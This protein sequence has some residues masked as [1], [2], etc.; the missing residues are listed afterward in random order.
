MGADMDDAH[1]LCRLLMVADSAQYGFWQPIKGNNMGRK[2]QR[3]GADGEREL[4][5]ILQEHGFDC[6]RGGSLSFGEVPDLS[7]LPGIHIEVK[8]VEKQN[9]YEWMA[10][11]HRDADKFRDGLPAVFWRKNRCPWLVVMD[12]RDWM[13]LYQL[14]EKS[15]NARF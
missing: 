7:G 3:K 8:R 10:Q 14:G 1:G 4:A 5:A 13:I 12:L 9:I 6:S 15:D 11:A 2:S